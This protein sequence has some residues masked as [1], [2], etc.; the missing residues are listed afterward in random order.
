MHQLIE[1]NLKAHRA[2]RNAVVP[3]YKPHFTLCVP[4]EGRDNRR[5]APP[6]GFPVWI[7]FLLE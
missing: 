3:D 2:P 6:L 5:C 1:Q 4:S 7:Q